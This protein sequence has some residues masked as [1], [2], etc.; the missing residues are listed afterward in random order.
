SHRAGEEAESLRIPVYGRAAT[1]RKGHRFTAESSGDLLNRNS[2]LDFN[3]QPHPS[4]NPVI[5]SGSEE[6]AFCWAISNASTA[7]PSTSLGMTPVCRRQCGVEKPD[8]FE[9]VPLKNRDG[10]ERVH[11]RGGWQPCLR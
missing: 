1:D 4:H 3:R 11:S 9:G 7:D 2:D 8:S 5:P 10:A 6:S